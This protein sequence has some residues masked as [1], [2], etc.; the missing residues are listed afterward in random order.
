MELKKDFYFVFF[1][2]GLE[3]YPL[4]FTVEADGKWLSCLDVLRE[5]KTE[6]NGNEQT[7]DDRR[8]HVDATD[9]GW[10]STD[11]CR[12][13]RHA[14]ETSASGG[15]LSARSVHHVACPQKCSVHTALGRPKF[16][17]SASIE[18]FSELYPAV[19]ASDW[20]W[21]SLIGSRSL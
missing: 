16:I 17:P 3:L 8:G 13:R 15:A 4:V 6:S 18:S 5:Q 14:D 11:R 7:T 21:S 20:V 10:A 2:T 19:L 12:D 1:F 9:D